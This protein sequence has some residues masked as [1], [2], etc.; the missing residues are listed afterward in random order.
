MRGIAPMAALRSPFMSTETIFRR[1]VLR[2]AARIREHL[3]G[4]GRICPL[5]ELYE[6]DWTEL[7]QNIHR[8]EFARERGWKSAA[9]SLISDIDYCAMRL[10]RRLDDFKSRLPHTAAMQ[11]ASAAEIASDLFS[12]KTEFEELELD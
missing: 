11:I 7:D 6:H 5:P 2:A 12:V 9:E 4:A 10:R 8:Y 1:Q 3:A